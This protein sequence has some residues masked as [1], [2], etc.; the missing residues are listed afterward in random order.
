MKTLVCCGGLRGRLKIFFAGVSLVGL[1]TATAPAMADGGPRVV[2]SV[3]PVH[4][5][6]AAVMGE[7]ASPTLLVDGAQSP[8]TYDL[9]PSE[10]LALERADLVFWVGPSLESFLT[11]PLRSLSSADHV[12]HLQNAKG[13][14][15]LKTRKGGAW[16][17]HAHHDHGAEHEHEAHGHEG[18][19]GNHASTGL[20]EARIDPHIWLNPDNA[21]AIVQVAAARLAKIDPANAATYRANAGAAADEIAVLAQDID[22]QVSAVRTRPYVVFH[23]A[24]QYFE[25]AFGLNAVGA[26]TLSPDRQ[27]SARRLQEIRAQ[28]RDLDARCVFREPQFAPEL[29]DTVVEGAPAR[30]GVLDPLGAD[31]PKGP[32]AYSKLLQNLADSLTACLGNGG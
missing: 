19:H 23:D 12:V 7:V 26:I 17:G 31:L 6:V 32:D 28:I 4:A 1:V 13:V 5:L 10:A 30:V 2:A 29:V 22:A 21:R 24:Y 3:K 18:E 14:H 16:A 8:H 9:K 25:R 15:L 20:P 11:R 27:P